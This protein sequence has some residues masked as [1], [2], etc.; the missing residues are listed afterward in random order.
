MKYCKETILREVT[1]CIYSSLKRCPDKMASKRKTN[2]TDELFVAIDGSHVGR[3]ISESFTPLKI[4]RRK[5]IF[6]DIIKY[7]KETTNCNY[8]SSLQC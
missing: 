1:I 7:E 2:P 8:S 3:K 5:K 6:Q 4:M